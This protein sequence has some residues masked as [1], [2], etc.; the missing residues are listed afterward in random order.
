MLVAT[1]HTLSAF[2]Q[3]QA[4][5]LQQAGTSTPGIAQQQ[6]LVLAAAM[7]QSELLLWLWKDWFCTTCF[8]SNAA[9]EDAA[10]VA[11]FQAAAHAMVLL[12]RTPTTSTTALVSRGYS[13][14]GSSSRRSRSRA[15]LQAPTLSLSFSDSAQ[16]H[17]LR[18]AGAVANVITHA[19]R[20]RIN[21]AVLVA[22]LTSPG[23]VELLLLNL[24]VAAQHTASQMTTQRQ[25]QQQQ[26]LHVATCC[27]TPANYMEMCNCTQRKPAHIPHSPAAFM[28]AR[29]CCNLG[30]GLS[31]CKCDAAS[32][33]NAATASFL[34][35]HMQVMKLWSRSHTGCSRGTGCCWKAGKL[36]QCSSCSA[37]T[38]APHKPGHRSFNQSR[39]KCGHVSWLQRS[40]KVAKACDWLNA[41]MLSAVL[42]DCSRPT[43]SD[44]LSVSLWSHRAADR[45]RLLL[46]R[47]MPAVN[48]QA[49]VA[50]QSRSSAYNHHRQAPAT[51]VFNPPSAC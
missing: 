49:L 35:V 16:L 19:L 29:S 6:Q 46:E 11:T 4:S 28:P 3:E 15:E 38:A 2:I 18:V 34:T 13:G 21:Q 50:Q 36:P 25:R 5:T 48:V 45:P 33:P 44:R 41:S 7:R 27:S 14:S 24:V 51:V 30:G 1:L 32:A 8:T 23:L 47:R 43:E 22:Q 9:D 17:L 40:T 26:Q 42:R 37:L 20:R 31:H 39:L 12:L 10:A